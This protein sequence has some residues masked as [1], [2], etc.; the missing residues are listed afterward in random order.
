MNKEDIEQRSCGLP[1]YITEN[2]ILNPPEFKVA[3]YKSL[4]N[5]KN[6]LIFIPSGDYYIPCLFYRKP[7]SSYILIYFHGNSEHIFQVEHYGLDFRT[8][9]EMNVI[10]VEYPG[11]SIYD[12]Q[13]PD[14]N[15]MLINALT[16][17]EWLN[18]TLKFDLSNIFVCG[19][20]I[21]TCPAIY[22][23]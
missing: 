8:H 19:R 1:K 5:F 7:E 18:K 23:A 6:K 14:P 9:L 20:S 16:V 12:S 11:Y 10:I 13:K 17:C 4:S 21:G 15:I 22:L 2:F 3:D